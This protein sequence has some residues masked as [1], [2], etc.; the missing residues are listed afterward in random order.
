VSVALVAIASAV[1]GSAGARDAGETQ[2]PPMLVFERGGDLY[3]MTVDGSE[4]VRLTA[5]TALEADPAASA[6][7]LTLAFARGTRRGSDELWVSDLR[8]QAQRRIVAARSSR[9]Q[10]ASTSSP[11]WALDGRSIYLARAAQGPNEICG[12]IYRVGADGRGLRRITRGVGLD[13]DPAP[14]PDGTR[15]ALSTGECEP[16]LECCF[17]S[18]VDLR[19]KPT[20]DLRRLPATSGGQFAP[21]WS[22]DG[23]RIAFEVK[24]LDVGT[25]GVY[26]ANRDGSGLARVT[27]RGLNASEPVWSPDGEWLAFVA[28]TRSTGDDVYIARPDGSALQRLMKTKADESSPTWIRRS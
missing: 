4:T 6:N 25:S 8:G 7:G 16:G 26:I 28:W 13:S 18:V 10:N 19:G 14:S 20:G 11:A 15:I 3:R 24:D 2:V 22:P 1:T 5:T 23:T 27:R 17:L 12:W 9:V 21:A